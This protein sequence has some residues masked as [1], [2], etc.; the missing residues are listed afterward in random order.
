MVLVATSIYPKFFFLAANNYTYRSICIV[1]PLII[2]KYGLV[3]FKE[4]K[5]NKTRRKR[6]YVYFLSSKTVR[7]STV[8]NLMARTAY[9]VTATEEE[10]SFI[11]IA[12]M[13]MIQF[14]RIVF[15]S[16]LFRKTS[17]DK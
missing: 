13:L 6:N 15:F 5:C 17:E 1:I 12:N 2:T 9:V 7:L 16:R 3:C 10:L 11:S 14:N 8:R 4:S